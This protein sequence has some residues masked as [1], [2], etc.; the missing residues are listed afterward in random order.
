M[1]KSTII[2]VVIGALVLAGILVLY[3]VLPIR[4]WLSQFQQYV[5][6]MGPAGYVLYALVYALC[7]V[8]FI[9]ASI[10]T[11]G[12][13]AVFGVVAGTIVVV[14]GATL[15]ATLAFLLA[16]TVL[17]RKIE[18]MTANNAKFHALDR[19]ISRDG[20]KIVLL[21]RLAVVFPF[22]YSNYAFGLTGVR[23][24]SYVGMTLIGIIP[25]TLAFVYIG[26]LATAAANRAT[27]VIYGVGALIALIVSTLV[28]RVATKAIKRAGVEEPVSS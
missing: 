12:A 21:V 23:L 19:A 20:A 4:E 5:R 26:S 24:L 2:K 11:V 18:H 14:C 25:G 13:G 6:G 8:L 7:V 9:P 27:L 10:L 3:K 17:R 15:G 1:S 28:A 22:T 16:R